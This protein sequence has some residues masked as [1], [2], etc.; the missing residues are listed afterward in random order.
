MPDSISNAEIYP[1]KR[2]ELHKNYS[3]IAGQMLYM[4]TV[5]CEHKILRR[6]TP[7]TH[8]RVSKTCKNITGPPVTWVPLSLVIHFVHIK[9]RIHIQPGCFSQAATVSYLSNVFQD[10]L[11][12]TSSLTHWGRVTQICVFTLQLC[13][14]DDANLHF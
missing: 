5:R 11:K 1:K 9:Q 10:A 6:N 3:I 7:W 13:K 8:A 4:S 12:N 14:T 2:N